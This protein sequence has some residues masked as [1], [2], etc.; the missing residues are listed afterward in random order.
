MTLAIRG[1]AS[2]IA[3]ALIDIL[4]EGET[5]VPVERGKIVNDAE[6]YLFCDGMLMPKRVSAQTAKERG[7]SFIANCAN[8][9]EACDM[10]IATNPDAR[11]CVIGSESAFCWSYDAS[12]AAAKAGLHR[13]VETKALSS[14]A[15]QLVCVAPSIIWDAGMTERRDD[16]DVLECKRLKHPKGRF[17]TSAEVAA[18]VH[19][20]LYV[21]KGYLSG[22]V[23]RMNGG[24]HTR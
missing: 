21:D 5:A 14:K 22:V 12:Y 10:I 15:Q 6:R 3:Q 13:Y 23:I 2:K 4:P 8:T 17:L 9:I 11:I 7:D 24:A 20:V 19:H 16:L 18:L 1:F